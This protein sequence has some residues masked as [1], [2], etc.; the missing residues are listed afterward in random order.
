[1]A[2]SSQWHKPEVNLLFGGKV[3]LAGLLFGCLLGVWRLGGRLG[4]TT[5]G[6]TL[7]ATPSLPATSSSLG[8]LSSWVIEGRGW[9]GGWVTSWPWRRAAPRAAPAPLHD[10]IRALE[11]QLQ[12]GPADAS[13]VGELAV[14]KA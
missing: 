13:G 12:R 11:Q 8:W 4:N 10:K 7:L 6:G 2:V 3:L 1:M 9:A 5:P 14:L